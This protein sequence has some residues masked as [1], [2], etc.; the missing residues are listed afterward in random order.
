MIRTILLAGLLASGVILYAF[1]S[2]HDGWWGW[3]KRGS[4]V[5]RA[6]IREVEKFTGIDVGGAFNVEV[7]CGKET[8]IE[9]LADDNLLEDIG[10]S[11]RGS[12]LYIET[13]QNISPRTKIRIHITTPNVDDVQSSGASDIVLNNVSNEKLHIETSGAGSVKASVKTDKLSVET[14]GAGNVVL[15]G[16]AETFSIETSGAADVKARDL[17][18]KN[19]RIDVS[20]AG[21]VEL[22]VSNELNVTVSGAGDIRYYGSPKTVSKE[23]SGAGSVTKKGD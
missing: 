23:V 10:T 19:A 4:G 6:E 12:T 16:N 8:K 5:E 18:T 13:K 3:G 11:V 7:T 17:K 21:D 15:S 9:V 22:S 14:S 20:G 1:N 2:K